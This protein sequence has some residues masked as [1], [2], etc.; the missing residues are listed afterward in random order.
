M[1]FRQQTQVSAASALIMTA[2]VPAG[3]KPAFEGPDR[4]E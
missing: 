4:F 3:T 2:G 1:A